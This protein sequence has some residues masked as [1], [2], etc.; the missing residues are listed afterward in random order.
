MSRYPAVESGRVIFVHPAIRP[1]RGHIYR[2]LQENFNVK[3]YLIGFEAVNRQWSDYFQIK[4][5]EILP[6]YRGLGYRSGVNL[7]LLKRAWTD[8]YDVWIGSTLY[9]FTTHFVYPIVKARRKK[10]IL[11]SEDW[12]WGGDFLSRLAIPLCNLIIRGSDIII[13]AWSKQKEFTCRN[14]ASET[15]VKIAYNSY[16]PLNSRSIENGDIAKLIYQKKRFRI[17]YL[18]RILEY[19]GLDILIKA[20]EPIEAKYSGKTELIVAGSGPF[21]S[22]CKDL[23]AKL[24]LNTVFFVGRVHPEEVEE[25]YRYADVFVHPCKWCTKKRVRGESWGFVINEAMSMGL[26]VVTTSAVGS[27]YD[28]IEHGQSGFVIQPGDSCSLTRALGTLYTNASVRTAIGQ[29]AKTRIQSFF[30]PERQ[31]AAFVEAV[32]ALL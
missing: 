16:T 28:L 15:K 27:A 8:N 21:E 1:Y 29:A 12:Y 10:F 11:W 26:P 14:G 32:R 2:E 24:G 20:Y 25:F 31:A 4:D 23:V 19:K 6:E 9:A 30:T 13:V 17:L 22:V 7:T 18:G 5:Y 3:F